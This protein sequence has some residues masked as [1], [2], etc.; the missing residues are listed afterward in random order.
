VGC[1]ELVALAEE[2][3]ALARTLPASILKEAVSRGG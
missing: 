1:A 3:L 2:N